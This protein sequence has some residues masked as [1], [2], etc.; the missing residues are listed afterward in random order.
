MIIRSNHDVTIWQD[1][2]SMALRR[3]KWTHEV[4]T[5]MNSL[6]EHFGQFFCMPKFCLC[7]RSCCRRLENTT[8]GHTMGKDGFVNGP[9]FS[10]SDPNLNIFIFVC[11]SAFKFG[12]VW[13]QPG[14]QLLNSEVFRMDQSNLQV[15]DPKKSY[16]FRGFFFQVF[17]EF[18]HLFLAYYISRSEKWRLPQTAADRSWSFVFAERK[19][20]R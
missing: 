3:A 5:K 6:R 14:D 17:L 12:T 4:N 13:R 16:S 1:A 19:K 11:P 7:S 18:F 10:R 15:S 9:M 8:D 20:I 2:I